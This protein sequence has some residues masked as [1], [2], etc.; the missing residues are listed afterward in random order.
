MTS[1]TSDSG[2][3][4]LSRL[5]SLSLGFEQDRDD[6]FLIN[7]IALAIAPRTR[8]LSP[9]SVAT[10]LLAVNEDCHLTLP[11][12]KQCLD[13]DDQGLRMEMVHAIIR[14][15]R[16]LIAVASLFE[17]LPSPKDAKA[18][19]INRVAWYP[20]N[21]LSVLACWH[22]CAAVEGSPV[23]SSEYYFDSPLWGVMNGLCDNA[24]DHDLS[25]PETLLWAAE[26]PSVEAIR[27]IVQE[28]EITSRNEIESLLK[29][30]S[31]VVSSVRSGVL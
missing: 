15:M 9:R 29:S 11:I 31:S 25:L 23:T 22:Y 30:Q 7:E 21:A 14:S 10:G 17:K 16:D 8:H 1:S 6:A 12:F 20:Y 28:R 24:D 27:D 19:P 2:E 4:D 18:S 5:G 13:T 3:L 26:H